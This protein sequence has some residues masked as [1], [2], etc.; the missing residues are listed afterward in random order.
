MVMPCVIDEASAQIPQ[1][2]WTGVY[3]ML[4]EDRGLSLIQL[5]DGGYLIAG[6]ARGRNHVGVRP[7]G[8]HSFIWNA[9]GLSSGIYF[10]RVEAE[11]YSETNKC[12]LLK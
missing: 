1:I 12:V 3:D 10:Y 2:E 7:A 11:S 4:S 6:T 9:D 5:D 8:T